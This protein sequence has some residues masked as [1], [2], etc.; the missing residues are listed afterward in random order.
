MSSENCTYFDVSGAPS[1]PCRYTVCPCNDNICQVFAPQLYCKKSRI[2]EWNVIASPRLQLVRDHRPGYHNSCPV[3][4]YKWP[5]RTISSRSGL[6]RQHQ[7]PHRYFFGWVNEQYS[8]T[9]RLTIN[10]MLSY[11]FQVTSPGG[12][13]VPPSICGINTGQHSK[14][15][16][17]RHFGKIS[18]F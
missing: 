4:N 6:Q 15:C 7:L 11:Q 14:L 12:S 1:G 9:I 10:W 5:N 18:C 2:V 8:N 16:P 3:Q 13:T 17:T